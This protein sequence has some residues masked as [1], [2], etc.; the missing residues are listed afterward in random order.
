MHDRDMATAS[1]SVKN[2]QAT[3]AP[4]GSKEAIRHAAQT[5]F[6]AQGFSATSV[7]DIAKAAEVNAALVIRHFRSKEALFLATMTFDGGFSR[8]LAGPLEAI[9]EAI[10]R[11]LLENQQEYLRRA[12]YTALMRSTEMEEVRAYVIKSENDTIVAPL[13]ARLS[14]PNARTRAGLVSAQ[15]S[16]LLN[17]LWILEIPDLTSE[18]ADVIVRHYGRAIQS[19]VDGGADSVR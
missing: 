3:R 15:I 16:G 19:L 10:V 14:G 2:P 1:P 4:G 6:A 7:R 17:A 13:A 8:L 5:L 18:S 11:R 9:G 12:Y